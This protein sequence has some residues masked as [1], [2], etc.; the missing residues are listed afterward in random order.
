MR[1]AGNRQRA[2]SLVENLVAIS[3]VTL[4]TL[5]FTGMIVLSGKLTRAARDELTA[6]E[7]LESKIES[8]RS[9]TWSQ[10]TSPKFVPAKSQVT[11][12]GI[13]TIT[14]ALQ[15]PTGSESYHDRLVQV[16]AEAKWSSEGRAQT[17]STTT[18]ISPHG[19]SST[20]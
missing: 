5:G 20:K 3:T 17:V 13:Y 16:V 14:M 8:L 19:S 7:I 1:I 2:F 9:C 4:F 18:F 10:I 12:G 11:N 15:N 6:M